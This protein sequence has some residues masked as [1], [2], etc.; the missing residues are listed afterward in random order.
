MV[1]G[2]TII[3]P[4]APRGTGFEFDRV[5]G[6]GGTNERVHEATTRPL[7]HSVMEGMNGTLLAY[8][9][10]H[11][12]MG[13]AEEP[14][15]I[16]LSIKEMFDYIEE[17]EQRE[18]TMSM[19]Y[20]EIYKER[21]IDLLHQ[22]KTGLE[23]REDKNNNV[24]VHN[25]KEYIV[26]NTEEVSKFINFGNLK[27]TTGVTNM[28]ELSSCSHAVLGIVVKSRVKDGDETLNVSSL[29]LID[30]AGSKTF[31][32]TGAAGKSA[33]DG[34]AI[35]LSLFTLNQVIS[36]LSYGSTSDHIPYRDSKLTHLLKNN[37]KGNAKIV[38][39]CADTPAKAYETEFTFMNCVAPLK[40]AP[41]SEK[42]IAAKEKCEGSR[43]PLSEM[44]LNTAQRGREGN[45]EEGGKEGRGGEGC[46]ESIPEPH[47]VTNEISSDSPVVT[48]LTRKVKSG[49]H[50]NQQKKSSR[51]KSRA[52]KKQSGNLICLSMPAEDTNGENMPSSSSTYPS[53]LS[54]PRHATQ[55]TTQRVCGNSHC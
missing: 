22:T 47:Q 6:E 43:L 19:S 23:I 25:L 5:F 49:S 14:G 38:I 16:L 1:Q 46:P 55:H 32:A 9:Q 28:N 37:L 45:M 27:R 31:T 54:S 36:K 17:H 40:K 50:D 34:I 18:F 30:L 20:L 41:Q 35:N 15:I 42:Q 7:V 4:T 44:R 51:R 53:I 39:I 21:I 48:T 24:S 29:N 52:G 12:M 11:M 33:Q 3:A 2:S 10:T 26:T 13:T 8:D